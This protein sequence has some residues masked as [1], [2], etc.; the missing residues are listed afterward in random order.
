VSWAGERRLTLNN[1]AQ[2][3]AIETWWGVES[4]DDGEDVVAAFAVDG[5]GSGMAL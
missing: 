4:A 1:V 5:Q 3:I 2:G